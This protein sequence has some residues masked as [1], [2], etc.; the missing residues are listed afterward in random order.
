[1]DPIQYLNALYNAARLAPLPA[2]DHELVK[3]A[4]ES[5]LEALKPKEA[6]AVVP[7]EP[8]TP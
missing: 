2:N 3:K 8:K 5:I 6:P 7:F 4:A 1:M